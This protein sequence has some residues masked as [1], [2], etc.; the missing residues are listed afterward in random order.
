MGAYLLARPD[1]SRQPVRVLARDEKLMVNLAGQAPSPLRSQGDHVFLDASG[2]RFA[3]DVTG[4]RATGFM[5]GSGLRRLEAVW[6]R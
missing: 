1:G 5:F 2:N 3:F 4:D 6:L